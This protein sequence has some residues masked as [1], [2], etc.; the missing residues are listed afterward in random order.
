MQEL[1]QGLRSAEEQEDDLKASPLQWM[2]C[3]LMLLTGSRPGHTLKVSAF[4]AEVE[5]AK[6][7]KARLDS[8]GEFRCPNTG[9]WTP[10]DNITL[11][12]DES[13]YWCSLGVAA[14][15]RDAISRYQAFA[16]TGLR[17]F[18]TH[19]L[20]KARKYVRCHRCQELSEKLLTCP[21]CLRAND[22][23][24]YG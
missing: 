8:W 16:D 22:I 12:A 20:E 1:L 11:A 17:G 15:L 2:Y 23:D 7:I 24:G 3:H 10:V 5:K 14:Q 18:T 13:N 19:H 6:S 4:L 21:G 9:G